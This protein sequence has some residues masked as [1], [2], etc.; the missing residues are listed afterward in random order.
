MVSAQK[1]RIGVISDLHYTH[2]SLIVEKGKVLDDY[3]SR[4]RKLLLESDAILRQT[5]KQLLQ[6]NVDIVFIPGDLTKDGEEVSH[7]G[8]AQLLRPLRRRGI[9]VLVI[10]GNHDINNPAAVSFHGDV[11]HRE[12]TVSADDFEMIYAEYGYG[13]AVSRDEYSLSYVSEPLEGFRV[14]CIDSNKYNENRFVSNGDETDFCVTHG[15]IRPETMEWIR[16]ETLVAKILDKQMVAMIHHNVVEH[17]T[18]Q[19]L[20]AAPYMVDNFMQVQ[21]KFLEYGINV[22]FTGHFHS[23]GISKVEDPYGNYLYEV[24]TG[25]VITYPCPYRIVEVVGRTLDIE[26]KYIEEIDYPLPDGKSFQTHARHTIEYG[27]NEMLSGFVGEYH[28]TFVDY[29]PAWTRSFISIP[30]AQTLTGLLMSNLSAHAVDMMLVHY[31]GNGY[32]SEDASGRKE[33]LLAGFDDFIRALTRASAGKFAG[34]TEKFI[35]R[36]PVIKKAKEAVSGIWDNKAV[37]Q[38]EG[39]I[40]YCSAPVND[41]RLTIKLNPV[42]ET[43]ITEH[44]HFSFSL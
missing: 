16:N 13:D 30:D 32:L 33:R 27:I 18:H 6:E 35:Q 4:D 40:A 36:M 31:S 22:L 42:K 19:G 9:K 10:P 5:V 2:P 24:E 8:V 28:H 43:P 7:H 12:A 39:G 34:V 3:L 23:S 21:K 11:T 26:T 25:S 37:R 1:A 41:L 20:F 38:N 15:A 14:L 17:F 29:L 44:K